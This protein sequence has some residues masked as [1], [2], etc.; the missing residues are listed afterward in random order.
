MIRSTTK[1]RQEAVCNIVSDMKL[2]NDIC[3]YVFKNSGSE[4]E[5]I[6]V[7]H[8]ST[9]A[10]VKKVF[11]DHQFELST[12]MPAYIFGIARY[13]WLTKIK[14]QGKN[15]LYESIEVDNT[16]IESAHFEINFEK[17]ERATILHEILTHLKVNCKNVL[18][19]WAGG[20]NM[21]EITSLLG[22]KNEAVVRKKKHECYKELI[23]WLDENPAYKIE[24]RN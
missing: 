7:F 8:D 16:R 2:K 18:M 10:F 20:Y 15:P 5:G 13:Q 9:V 11:S 24:L 4:D 23:L 21:K 19:Y 14:K 6:M 17:K 1:Q 3:K 12:S 22:Y